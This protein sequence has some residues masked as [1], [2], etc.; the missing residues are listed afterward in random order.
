MN[1]GMIVVDLDD[2]LLDRDKRIS[3]RTIS[4]L[5]KC[6]YKGIKIV[7]AT[8]RGNSSK[9]LVPVELFDGHVCMNGAMAYMGDLLMYSRTI[10]MD[11]ARELLVAAHKNNIKIA[12]ES[13]GRHYANFNVNQ[14]WSYITDYVEVDFL[15]LQ[16]EAEKLYA[17]IEAPKDLDLINKHLHPGLYLSV[18]RDGLAMIMHREAKKSKAVAFLSG[19]WN[20]GRNEIIAFGDDINDIDMLKQ[21]G[22]AVAMENALEEVKGVADYICGSNTEEGVAKWLEENLL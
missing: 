19:Y 14:R 9:S 6:R 21:C 4:I 15:G 20:I 22:T 18:S 16:I 7:Y 13:G 10:N 5:K 3:E 12:A 11:L 1:I 2:T 8:A 17:I